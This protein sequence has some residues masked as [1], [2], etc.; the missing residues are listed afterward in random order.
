METVKENLILKNKFVE[1][2]NNTVRLENGNLSEHFRIGNIK[3]QSSGVCILPLNNKGEV[4]VLDEYRYGIQDYITNIP[5]GA[6]EKHL[7]V[8]ESAKKELLEEA[9]LISNNLECLDFNIKSDPS[10][11]NNKVYY[12]IAYDCEEVDGSYKEETEMFKNKRWVN[13]HDL[14]NKVVR[15]EVYINLTVLPILFYLAN[16]NK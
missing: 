9:G 3:D 15:G 5:T 8:E 10:I 7:S 6:V 11:K 16:K 1:L 12:F 14:Y 4:F 2:Y 13:L